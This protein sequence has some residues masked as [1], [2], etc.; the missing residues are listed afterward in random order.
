MEVNMPA[1]AQ[2]SKTANHPDRLQRATFPHTSAELL[3]KDSDKEDESGFGAAVQYSFG[4]INVNPNPQIG[5]LQRKCAC[6]GECEKCKKLQRKSSALH[7]TVAGI[8]QHRHETEADHVAHTLVM[9]AHAPVAPV[10][11]LFTQDE[12]SA[13]DFTPEVTAALASPGQPLNADL[14]RFFEP[15][16]GHDF[17][18]VRVHVD[19]A[20]AS[21]VTAHAFTVGEHIVFASDQYRP[22]TYEGRRLLAHELTHV[23]QQSNAGP[24]TPPAR[25]ESEARGAGSRLL[26]GREISVAGATSAT[27]LHRDEY[28]G[29]VRA[30]PK[31]NGKVAVVM[32]KDGKIV[33][34]Y[35]EITPPPGMMPAEA[36]RR[37]SPYVTGRRD[38]KGRLKVDVVIPPDWGR[39]ATN[40]ASAVR[41]VDEKVHEAEVKAE[42]QVEEHKKRIERLRDL[43]R[44]Y[45][46]EL[47]ASFTYAPPDGYDPFDPVN[48]M[49]EQEILDLKKDKGFFQWMQRRRTQQAKAQF[50]AEWGGEGVD[51]EM[52]NNAW[53]NTRAED[54]KDL[55]ATET[56]N[57]EVKYN[58]E[59][60]LQQSDQG[61][62]ILLAWMRRK[63][64]PVEI[65]GP[66]GKTKMYKVPALDGTTVDITAAQFARLRQAAF[67]IVETRL[68]SVQRD[69]DGYE[70][71]KKDR[72]WGS[73]RLDEVYGAEVEGKAW[74]PGRKKAKEGKDA[75]KSGDLDAS[76]NALAEAEKYGAIARKEN[77]RSEHKREVGAAHTI[78]GLELVE[79]GAD[80]VLA[81]GTVPMGGWGLVLVTGKG[82]TQTVALAAL[83][84]GGQHVDVKDVAFDVGVQLT[85]AAVSHGMGKILSVGAKSPIMNVLRDTLPG[86]VTTD[87]MQMV[88]LD[89]ATHAAKQEYEVARGRREKFT[90][91]DF[92]DH[93]AKYVTDPESL[94]LELVKARAMRYATHAVQPHLEALPKSRQE[95]RERKA[96]RANDPGPTIE[97]PHPGQPEHPLAREGTPEPAAGDH[98]QAPGAPP[99]HPKPSPA[100]DKEKVA[101]EVSG[102][103]KGATQEKPDAPRK[104]AQSERPGEP[105]QEPAG[106]A[107][108]PAEGE[109][110]LPEDQARALRAALEDPKNLQPVKDP[111]LL[112]KGYVDEVSVGGKTFRRKKKGGTWCRWA[113][114]QECGFTA[115]K[116]TEAAADKAEK[117]PA[118]KPAETQPAEPLHDSAW[119]KSGNY[120][121]AQEFANKKLSEVQ[122]K[123]V[124]TGRYEVFNPKEGPQI[125]RTRDNANNEEVAKLHVD[126]DGFVRFTKPDE[127][128]SRAKSGSGSTL[129]QDPNEAL[130]HKR[131]EDETVR[132]LAKA[133]GQALNAN[134]LHTAFPGVDVFSPDEVAST[135]AYQGDTALKRYAEDFFALCGGPDK[136]GGGPKVEQ[137]ARMF[138]RVKG[139]W[140]AKNPGKKMPVPDEFVKNPEGY[141]KKDATLR[142]PQDQ[143]IAA[144]DYIIEQ[145]TTAPGNE[146]G[147]MNIGREKGQPLS[148]HDAEEIVKKRVLGFGKDYA[149]LFTPEAAPPSPPA[150][151]AAV[152]ATGAP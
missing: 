75:L 4:A 98:A 40:P 52:L 54:M 138:E 142:I 73:R 108:K 86:Q 65:D 43:Y 101:V 128:K 141:L 53:N 46:G 29:E 38:E 79:K 117:E 96:A 61:R 106:Q 37:I 63:P 50:K 56:N 55:E 119:E 59:K 42:Q 133:H 6:G 92:L 74:D 9:H 58:T 144:Q 71:K 123:L 2:K 20:A 120:A 10:H 152:A 115:D 104:A 34:G 131:A 36:A 26:G 27:A 13:G 83:Q 66:N 12:G 33:R 145:I 22:A 121:E 149:D 67:D 147:H 19:D 35:A 89:A 77:E 84:S 113:S 41:V 100:A 1:F 97:P 148:A 129:I 125:R 64:Q 114:P 80:L 32:I 102:F 88:L 82:V 60:G 48:R 151:A 17:S 25:L 126:K 49:S 57:F 134:D 78:E 91:Q 16:F 135:K 122:K 87:A 111:D 23:V 62:N 110:R 137:A 76:L 118:P 132:A 116:P 130:Y 15:R 109:K 81:V 69:M 28:E 39:Q 44:Q 47:M 99:E 90:T 140:Q 18:R 14:R 11:R 5:V 70:L 107:P 139:E 68:N 85:T 51:D 143:V 94:P 45:R 127:L 103:D 150:A 21:S 146:Y 112:A 7:Q 3:R 124:E 105:P 136:A 95:A 31:E 93:V 8:D 24:P 30:I 72:G